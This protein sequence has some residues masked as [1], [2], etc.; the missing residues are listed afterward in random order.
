[1]VFN[2]HNG[3]HHLPRCFERSICSPWCL[4]SYRESFWSEVANPSTR[5]GKR[6]MSHCVIMASSL[7]TP[8]YTW[9]SYPHLSI[10]PTPSSLPISFPIGF[11]CLLHY[12]L[13]SR[14]LLEVFNVGLFLNQWTR[15]SWCDY[16]YH[17]CCGE[18]DFNHIASWFLHRLIAVYDSHIS[19]PCDFKLS[20]K[21]QGILV[22]ISELLWC[23]SLVLANGDMAVLLRARCAQTPRWLVFIMALTAWQQSL[24]SLP[25]P[26]LSESCWAANTS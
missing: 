16:I 22:V 10:P 1:M 17:C 19:Q 23:P 26:S 7:T 12:C 3:S 8:V 4:V 2:I 11:M 18:L 25:H 9:V 13:Y 21:K 5:S 14:V 20:I 24:T 6:N 15:F